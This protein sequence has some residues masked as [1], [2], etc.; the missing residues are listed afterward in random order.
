MRSS[1]FLG[2]TLAGL[3]GV[4]CG[5]TPPARWAEGGAPLV[6]APARWDRGDSDPIEILANGQVLEDGDPILLV[7]RAGRVVDEDN[8]PVAILL[9]D[10]HVAGP[11][12]RLLGRVGLGNAAPP[13][14][15]EAWISI[16]P[17]GQ[18]VY[19]DS[20]GDRSNGGVWR[21]CNG[22]QMRTCTLVTHIIAVQ[23]YMR[24][25][26]SGVSVGVGIGVGF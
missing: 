17:N 22:P 11:D 10:G 12:N 15:V 20:D 1:A 14:A 13:D 6:V 23:R 21:G 4:A 19:F 9:P 26:Q 24:A 25:R 3:L 2:A 16:L 8:E 7:D 18:V 5:S